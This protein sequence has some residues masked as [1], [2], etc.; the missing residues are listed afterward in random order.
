M[1]E[2]GFGYGSEYQLLRFMGRYRKELNNLIKNA[3]K[4][5]VEPSWFDFIRKADTDGNSKDH[6]LKGIEFLKGDESIDFKKLM[7]MW[8]E[9]WPTSGNA[10][11]WDGIF[12]LDKT[13]VLVEA[14]AH[15][16]EIEQ[17]CGAKSPE[18][19][20]QINKAL[21]E[22]KIRFGVNTDSDWSKK[23]YQLANR[24][25]FIH[26]LKTHGIDARLLYIYFLNGYKNSR[27]NKNVE[28]IKVWEEAVEKEHAYLGITKEVR[29]K[30]IFSI[31]P[32][33]VHKDY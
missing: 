13:Y 33:C 17:T 25:A 11:N 7:L 31:Y 2:M 27:E 3:M 14:K 29:D 20:E 15:I 32:N 12:K 16:G 22:T 9:Y 4:I 21:E 10:H 18:S 26:F 1:G 8:K 6:E 24:L 28:E 30:Y 19:I 23:Y 5:S